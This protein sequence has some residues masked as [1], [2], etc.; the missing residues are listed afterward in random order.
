MKKQSYSILIATVV[1][2]YVI[3]SIFFKIP[4]A[5]FGYVVL[6]Q[7]LKILLG[8]TAY[9]IFSLLGFASLYLKYGS[10]QKT[11]KVL[12]EDYD[13]NYIHLAQASLLNLIAASGIGFVI[14]VI[15]K[16]LGHH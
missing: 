15:Y 12:A 14:W 2:V 10:L 7:I 1:G 5:S 13:N 11:R 8:L 9:A 4:A 6:L 3:L 16:T